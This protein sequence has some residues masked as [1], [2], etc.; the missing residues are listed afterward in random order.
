MSPRRAVRARQPS[1][2][3]PVDR[4]LLDA[5]DLTTSEKA[6]EAPLKKPKSLKPGDTV[7]IVAPS[8][9]CR[10]ERL[11]QGRAT[12]ESWGLRVEAPT[13][14]ENV[15]YLAASDL[16]RSRQIEA[17]LRNPHVRAVLTS[18][19][20]YGAARL[21]PHLDVRC[22]SGDPKIFVG[23]S[24]I[25]IL[26]TRI[27]QEA[28]VV[29]YHGPMVAADLPGLHEGALE[30]F[31]RFLFG[32]PGWWDGGAREVWRH[33]RAEAAL[34]GGCLSVLV[35]TLGTPYEIDTDGK[36]LF[37]EDVAEKPYRIDRMLTHLKHAGKLSHVEAVVLGSML[38]CDDGSGPEAIRD[39]VLDVCAD[40]AVP[41][42][43]G[44]QAGHGAENVVLPFGCRVRVDTDLARLDLLEPVFS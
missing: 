22:V 5:P 19:G 13:R 38:D 17:A 35:T 32:E 4:R 43:Y 42:L 20:G 21:Y 36:I 14:A 10:P 40:L 41:I 31:R 2:D 16:D 9:A 37:L 39:I 23:F 18:R 27:V 3:P 7:A 30:R 24:D 8:G 1:R 28:G 26:L 44:L 29:S 6:T 33:G 34:T 15:R 25:T 12:L 11:E